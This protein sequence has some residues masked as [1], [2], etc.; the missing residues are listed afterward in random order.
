MFFGIWL[1]D[2]KFFMGLNWLRPF[3]MIYMKYMKVGFKYKIAGESN[4][5]TIKNKS[6]GFHC[7]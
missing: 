5:E 6:S 3:F 4:D 1:I 7:R 2:T